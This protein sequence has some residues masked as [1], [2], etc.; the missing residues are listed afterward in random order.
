M[1]QSLDHVPYAIPFTFTSIDDDAR[2]SVQR[3]IPYDVAI[4]GITLSVS[5]TPISGFSHANI[6]FQN[7]HT[8]EILFDQPITNANFQADA[9]NY[10]KLPSK[11]F[12]RKNEK[13][14]CTLHS[15]DTVSTVTYYITLL[16][17]VTALD[18]NPGIQPFVYSFQIPIGFQD[19]VSA[20]GE[21]GTIF[22]QAITGTMAKHMLHDFEIHAINFDP[23]GGNP[24]IGTGIV[25]D[26]PIMAFQVSIQRHDGKKR[27]LFDRFIIDGVAGGG[28]T[29]AQGDVIPWMA[30]TVASPYGWPQFNSLQYQLP[31]P[32]LVKKR[33]LIRVDV[34]PAPT[35]MGSDSIHDGLNQVCTMAVIGN[36]LG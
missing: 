24:D 13:I 15:F 10:F 31:V 28:F 36:H 6:Q 5:S 8:G 26:E 2:S 30:G 22:N 1:I 14:I 4:Y 20:S 17:H 9:R 32:E 25:Q 12:V 11:W 21:G 23:W 27:K 19:N 29:Y 33:E 35:Y 7:F 16:G 34:S 3:L 18:P